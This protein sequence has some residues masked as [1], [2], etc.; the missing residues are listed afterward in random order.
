MKKLSSET[1]KA[2]LKATAIGL[3]EV[4]ADVGATSGWMHTDLTHKAYKLN[5][6]LTLASRTIMWLAGV[7][8]REWAAVHRNHHDFADTPKDPHSPVT[9]GRWGVQKEFIMNF[10]DYRKEAKA[11]HPIPDPDLQPDQ[12][13]LDLF[14]NKT[15]GLKA[16]LELHKALNRRWG[17]A[18]EWGYVSWT[19]AKVGYV[20]AG[21]AVNAAGHGGKDLT[22]ALLTGKIEPHEDGTYG[23]DARKLLAP[24]LGEG[25]QHYHHLHPEDVFFAEGPENMSLGEKLVTDA[26]GTV[27][28]ELIKRGYAEPGERPTAEAA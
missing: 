8:P 17:N 3:G 23:T 18:E 19:V 9:R 16:S 15:K 22:K 6:N 12:L 7:M 20:V 27:A 2:L 4:A 21:S 13:D 28:L 25:N 1:K 26:V 5:E 11:V 14:D 24:F 10:W